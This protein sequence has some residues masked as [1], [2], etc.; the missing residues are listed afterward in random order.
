VVFDT[1]LF[2][3][4]TA[5]TVESIMNQVLP[6][7]NDYKS[8]IIIDEKE[9]DQVKGRSFFALIRLILLGL[10]VG[11]MI[12]WAVNWGRNAYLYVHE[13][14]ARV[15]ADLVPI[16][17]QA[18]G[19]VTDLFFDEGA[20]I[21][22]GQILAKVDDR[23]T[24][25]KLV[26]K[27]AERQTQLAELKRSEAEY[28]MVETQ[29]KSRI[30]GAK[31]R[32]AEA[33]VSKKIFTHEFS[34]V[35][36]EMKRIK[37]LVKKGAVSRSRFDRSQ[38]DFFKAQQ[39][40]IKSNAIIKTAESSLKEAM[41]DQS[42]LIVKVAELS[43]LRAQLIEIDA[44]IAIQEEELNNFITKADID[45]VVGRRLIKKGEFVSKGQRLLVMHD[46]NKIWIET[47]IRETEINRISPG[48]Q[49]RIEVDAFPG[50]DFVGKVILIGNAATSQFALLP[51]LN[52]AG[53]F[54][55]ITQRIRVR[56]EVEQ[57]QEALKPGMMVEVFIDPKEE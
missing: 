49:V 35:E 47:N 34:F 42:E 31:S 51:K 37:K 41:A 23:V 32:L 19:V 20:R 45:G 38:A 54:T 25:L 52:E 44:E 12:L 18:S 39:Q 48:R 4:K 29:L 3:Q 30:E 5:L 2:L 26:Q 9:I 7:N 57:E 11:A 28:T 14:D 10:L 8:D 6:N 21:S 27:K 43:K 24:Q 16:S 36:K 55:K 46:P 13:T 53:T 17:S 56:I 22:A 1:H 40:L 50:K 33:R 15:M